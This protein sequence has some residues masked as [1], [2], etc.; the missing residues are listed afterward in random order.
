M[1]P[2]LSYGAD[3]WYIEVAYGFIDYFRKNGLTFGIFRIYNA[4]PLRVRSLS[5]L[6]FWG[7]CSFYRISDGRDARAALPFDLRLRLVGFSRF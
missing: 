3:V 1:R 6:D 7:G 5:G 2:T 4:P